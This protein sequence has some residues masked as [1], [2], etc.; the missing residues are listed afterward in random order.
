MIEV[1]EFLRR[2]GYN[3][4]IMAFAWALISSWPVVKQLPR[5]QLWMIVGGLY[6]SGIAGILLWFFK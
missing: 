5:L 2:F 3:V 4:F 6:I 1:L